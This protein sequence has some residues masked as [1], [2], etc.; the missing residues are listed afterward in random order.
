MS[1][2]IAAHEYRAS[3]LASAVGTNLCSRP[4]L[5]PWARGSRHGVRARRPASR[6]DGPAG[7]GAAAPRLTHLLAAPSSD[8]PQAFGKRPRRQPSGRRPGGQPGHE[9]QTRALLP[10]EEVDVIIPVTPTRCSRCQQ[11]LQGEDL[12]PQRHQVTESSPANPVVTEYQLHR[13]VCPVCGELTRAELP[14]GVPPGEFGPRVHA[15]AALCTGAYHLSKR[16]TQSVL[17]DLF[18]VSMSLGT[19]AN[20][21]QATAQAVAVPVAEARSYVHQQPVAY[22]DET[23]WREGPHRAWLWTA[24]TAGVTVF[25]VRLSR[26]GK[27][28]QE[29]LGTQFWGWLVTDRWSGYSWYPTWRRQLCWAHLLRDIEAMIARGGRF[30]EDLQ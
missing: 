17:D 12:Q 28:A 20:L 3:L 29:L 2:N 5:H 16:A 25:V 9:G 7:D 19:L 14:P 24:V 22:L 6:G 27:V 10:V 30:Q 23:G 8:P 1:R 4:R 15:I 21:E 18:G 26:S 13:L 11:P